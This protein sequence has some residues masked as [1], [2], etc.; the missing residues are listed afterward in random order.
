MRSRFAVGIIRLACLLAQVNADI[1]VER[2]GNA[3][4]DL[5]ANRKLGNRLDLH[6]VGTLLNVHRQGKGYFAKH[7]IEFSTRLCDVNI[8]WVDSVQMIVRAPDG[9]QFDLP[10]LLSIG[11]FATV[12]HRI[13]LGWF[14]LKATRMAEMLTLWIIHHAHRHKV[15]I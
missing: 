5:R 10:G 9:W 7:K 14:D 6:P 8:G 3:E 11:F 4:H 12:V 15:R 2:V 1:L 13:D